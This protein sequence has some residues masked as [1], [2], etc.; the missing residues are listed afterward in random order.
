VT[1]SACHNTMT[2]ME[3]K[4]GHAIPIVS[5]ARVVPAGV[6]RLTELQEEGWAY[7]RP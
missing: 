3:K 6:V 7:I 2:K 5:E 4:E 1:Y